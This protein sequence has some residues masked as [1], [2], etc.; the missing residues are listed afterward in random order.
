MSSRWSR[1]NLV[2]FHP[3]SLY[4]GPIV[5]RV[6]TETLAS[7]IPALEAKLGPVEVGAGRMGV[8]TWDIACTGAEGP[9]VLQ[10]PRVLDEPG[11][12]GRAVRDVP[13]ANVETMRHFAAR[14]LARFVVA[15]KDLLTLGEV[16]AAIFAALPEHRPLTFGRGALQVELAEGPLSWLVAL[17]AGP[18]AELLAELVAALAYHYDEEG[19]SALTDVFVNDGDFVVRRRPDGTF[20]LRLTAARRRS[21]GVAPDLLLL[22]LTQLMAHEDWQVGDTLTGLPTL[23]ANPSVAFAGMVRGR[24]YRSRDLGRPEADGEREALAWI[25]AFGRSPTGRSYRPFVD[26]FLDGQLPLAFGADPRE[27]WWR[28]GPVQ[29]QLGVL[30][31]EARQDPGAAAAARTLRAFVDRMGR[32]IGRRPADEAGVARVN[33]LGRDELLALLAEAGVADGARPGV[34]AELLGRWPFRG[35]DHLVAQVP[36]AR[37]LRRLKSRLAFGEVVAADMQGTLASLGAPPRDDAAVR[38]IANPETFGNLIVPPALSEAAVQTFPSFEAYMDAA[39]HDPRWGYYGHAV[40]IGQSGHFSTHPEDFSP[41]YGR[42]LATWAVRCWREMVARGELTEAD[43]FPIVEFGAG[44]GRLAR[45]LLDAVAAASDSE[46]RAF[47]ERLQYRIYETSASLRDRQRQLLGTAAIVA[48]GDARRPAETLGRDF[49]DGLRGLVLTNEVPDAFGV[50]KVV[51][52]AGGDARAALVVPRVEAPLRARLPEALAGQIDAADAAVRARFG[53]TGNA[54]DLYLDAGSFGAVMAEIAACPEDERPARRAALWFEE[55][56]V[57]AAAVPALAAHLAANAAAYA[58]A[59]AARDDGVVAYVNVH[60]GRFMRGLGAALAAGWIVTIDY[61]DTTWGLVQGARRGD[62]PFRVYG[63]WQG[64][65]PRPNDPYAAPGT[66]DLTADVSFTDLAR[67]G[68]EAGLALVHYGP[69]RD[70]VG[71]DLPR[72][73]RLAATDEGVAEFLG[74]AVFKVLVLGRRPSDLFTGPL[75]SPLSLEVREQDLPKGRRGRV[76]EIARKLRG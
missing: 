39:L 30:E 52:G 54:G 33:D 55:A 20:D 15:P 56:Y 70:L 35:V 61:G 29:S 32:E 76:A 60:A 34:A 71:D 11:T 69:E 27:R 73:L 49:P 66:Q 38:P 58:T 47:A 44:N 36:G 48:E 18:T 24:R 5:R 22:Y 57:P 2:T 16:P 14:G 4:D 40:T 59:L 7:L 63:D 42:W 62:F 19:G 67:A 23:I 31:L 64:N 75:L 41:H 65:V 50:H 46:G 17:G 8:V 21:Q 45:D 25:R 51:L 12:D 3:A 26:R 53:F 37:P 10:L 68:A 43:R 28:L 1:D 9:F 13:R 74:N 72:L 6:G